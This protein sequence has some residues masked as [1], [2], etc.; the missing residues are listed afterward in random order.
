M[1]RYNTKH[2]NVHNRNRHLHE[3]HENNQWH[4]VKEGNKLPTMKVKELLHVLTM[5]PADSIVCVSM[6]DGIKSTM[7]PANQVQVLVTTENGK[8]KHN[9]I[10]QTVRPQYTTRSNAIDTIVEKNEETI[11]GV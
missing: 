1:V 4:H 10:I 9:V 6:V 11:K 2:Y 7:Y 3:L 8:E 5:V